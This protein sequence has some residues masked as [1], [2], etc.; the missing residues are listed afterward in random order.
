VAPLEVAKLIGSFGQSGIQRYSLANLI[1][2]V[3]PKSSI[4]E[5]DT[6][7]S[8]LDVNRKPPLLN[9]VPGMTAIKLAGGQHR[10]AALKKYKAA[11]D[12]KGKLVKQALEAEI[13][14]QDSGEASRNRIAHW[15]SES[16]RITGELEEYG[17]W[18][19][20]VY[21]EGKFTRLPTLRPIIL[22]TGL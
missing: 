5:V 13:L 21:D 16:L 3:I 12:D 15:Q 20:A 11:L 18:G 1:P 9:F 6:L 4:L 17:F 10:L 8:Q 2:L 7:P 14:I 22:L 19:V